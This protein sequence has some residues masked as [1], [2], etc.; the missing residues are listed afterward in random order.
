MKNRELVLEFLDYAN[1]FIWDILGS[2]IK[3]KK[4]LGKR[5]EKY[6]EYVNAIKRSYWLN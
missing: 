5:S 1:D 2:N 4:E 3:S 6:W